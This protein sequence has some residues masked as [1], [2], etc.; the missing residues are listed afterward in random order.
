MQGVQKNATLK[1]PLAFSIKIYKLINLHCPYT[2][3]Y[4]VGKKHKPIA[5]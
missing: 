3:I 4:L 2:I 1:N 5:V